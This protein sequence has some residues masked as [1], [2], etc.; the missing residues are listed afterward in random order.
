MSDA[1]KRLYTLSR[2]LCKSASQYALDCQFKNDKTEK[3]ELKAKSDELT[4]KASTII[5]VMWIAIKD[6]LMLWGESNVGIRT[7]FK[8]ITFES[9]QSGLPPFL[10]QLFGGEL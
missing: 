10:Q 6:E 3:L 8:V 5:A 1:V 2:H 4:A 7:G 9:N